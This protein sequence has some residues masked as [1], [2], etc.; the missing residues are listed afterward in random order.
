MSNKA[1]FE[2]VTVTGWR[3]GFSPLFKKELKTWFGTNAWWQQSLLW[4][5]ILVLFGSATIADSE[6]P[7]SKQIVVSHLVTG[8]V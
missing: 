5:V 4:S 3:M 6:R 1:G 7:A 8:M 2:P